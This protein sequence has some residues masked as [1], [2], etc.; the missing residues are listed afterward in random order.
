[1]CQTI[2]HC[3]DREHDGAEKTTLFMTIT[4]LEAVLDKEKFSSLIVIC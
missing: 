1:M 3:Y 2:L 4:N